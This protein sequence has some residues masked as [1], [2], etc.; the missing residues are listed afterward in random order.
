MR[1]PFQAVYRSQEIRA[2]EQQA[3]GQP[4]PLPLMERAG[5]AAA[6]LA[7]T[8]LR[9]RGAV[10]VLAGPGNNGGDALVAARHLKSWWY[11]VGVVFTGDRER[12]PPDAARALSRWLEAGGELLEDIP[13]AGD[14]GLVLDGLF[15]IGL[16]R[17]LDGRHL[18]L[19][20]R[21][22]RMDC[23]VLALDIPSGLDS[24]T[25]QPFRGAVRADHTLTFIAL[26]PG[27]LTAYGPDYCGRLHLDT[28]GLDPAELPEPKG[29]LLG[30]EG[31][32]PL[33]KPRPSNSHKGMLGSVGVLGGADSMAGAALLAGRAALKLGAGRV[34]LGLLAENAPTV[35]LRQ[36][37][38]MFRPPEQLLELEQL[39]C[40]VVGPG[41]GQSERALRLLEQALEADLPL[42]LD[43]DAL[44]LLASHPELA[45]KLKARA[46]DAILTP[47][48]G[49][50]GRLLAIGT[51]EVQQD[52][53]GAAQV[54]AGRLNCLLVLKG[55]GTVCAA[56][57][58]TWHLNP[59]GNPGLSSAGMGDVLS[60][61][62][63][64]LVAQR[65]NPRQA[66][67]LAVHLHGLAADELVGDGRGPIGLTASEVSDRARDILN[68]W[69]Y[70][71]R[72]FPDSLDKPRGRP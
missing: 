60:G 64:A 2:I 8:L 9:D 67:L 5:L 63:G 69:V 25:G 15:G 32:A 26:K 10:L 72:P 1:T 44:N 19:V 50:A 12:L 70:P 65:L 11:R 66:M 48:P 45:D 36:P 13:P 42:V 28:L 3:L 6:E 46:K 35:D 17:D 34:Y 43:A 23:P 58:D 40:L 24:D 22:N 38:L 27:L 41:L 53:I 16:A 29:R 31:V 7:R 21:V 51:H 20:K 14:W 54:L 30:R 49:E 57:D 68:G 37:E 47:H 55:A 56:P 59:S 4:N 18:D 33:L 39:S 52:R 62:L 71:R 61:M